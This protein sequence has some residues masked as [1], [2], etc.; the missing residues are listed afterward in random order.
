M[1]SPRSDSPTRQI[2]VLLAVAGLVAILSYVVIVV[3]G[4]GYH[5]SGPTP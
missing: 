3:L 5:P 2:V 1:G 4:V